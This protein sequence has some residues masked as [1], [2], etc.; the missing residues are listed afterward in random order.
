MEAEQEAAAWVAQKMQLLQVTEG[1][2]EYKKQL[3]E[4][5]ARHVESVITSGKDQ[6]DRRVGFVEGLRFAAHLP[7]ALIARHRQIAEAPSG[8][9]KPVKPLPRMA[10]IP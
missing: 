10:D 1:W 9:R 3:A 4:A 8:K 5:E 7:D 2:D 6:H